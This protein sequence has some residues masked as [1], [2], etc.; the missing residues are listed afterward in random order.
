MNV[1]AFVFLKANETLNRDQSNELMRSASVHSN[2]TL[3]VR[4]FYCSGCVQTYNA[5][6]AKTFALL[7]A[8][9]PECDA[10]LKMDADSMMCFNFIEPEIF[11]HARN[12]RN[13][14]AGRMGMS[15]PS[16][17]LNIKSLKRTRNKE[18]AQ[19]YRRGVLPNVMFASGAGYF[20]GRRVAQSIAMRD[21]ADYVNTGFE[22]VNTGLFASNLNN[23]NYVNLN[24]SDKSC[25]SARR[26][27]VHHKCKHFSNICAA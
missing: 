1:C 4:P 23:V 20:V 15:G 24:G 22:D 18:A 2:L 12:V 11:R 5:L 14:Y 16:M 25:H 8:M 26:V 19:L 21:D 6:S 3:S 7:R 13:L 27:V 17:V 10:L 9:P